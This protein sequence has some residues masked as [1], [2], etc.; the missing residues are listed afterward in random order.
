MNFFLK[1]DAQ[2]D[3]QIKKEDFSNEFPKLMAL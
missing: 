2:N 1:I 3:S